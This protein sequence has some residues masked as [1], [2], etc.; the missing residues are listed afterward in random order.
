MWL[1]TLA[2]VKIPDTLLS[3]E[4]AEFDRVCTGINGVL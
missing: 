4:S 1:A 2:G 3:S